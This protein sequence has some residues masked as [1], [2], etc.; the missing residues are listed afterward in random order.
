MTTE[1]LKEYD[2][3]KIVEM[4]PFSAFSAKEQ[5]QASK[6]PEKKKI[7]IKR[8]VKLETSTKIMDDTEKE[9]NE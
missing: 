3:N 6:S 5:S 7:V 4:E 2:Y 1:Y 9:E 8:P